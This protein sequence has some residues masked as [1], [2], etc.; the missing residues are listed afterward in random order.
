ML[1]SGSNTVAQ[2][3]TSMIGAGSVSF[4]GVNNEGSEPSVSDRKCVG[5]G[6]IR[7]KM[8]YIHSVSENVAD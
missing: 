5:S 3:E 7:P 4:G 1:Q 6:G 2:L 8:I